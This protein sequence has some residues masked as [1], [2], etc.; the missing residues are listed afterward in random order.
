[1]SQIPGGITVSKASVYDLIPDADAKVV[2]WIK[3]W[4]AK[5][6]SGTKMILNKMQCTLADGPC[7]CPPDAYVSQCKG[8]YLGVPVEI[9]IDGLF[10][11]D[12]GPCLV[13]GVVGL[14]LPGPVYV[15]GL[16]EEEFMSSTFVKYV[17]KT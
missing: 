17:Q 5:V 13:E 11:P 3:A 6:P 12:G 2:A 16:G 7:G 4:A 1:M 15:Q 10:P 9:L 8:P 14:E